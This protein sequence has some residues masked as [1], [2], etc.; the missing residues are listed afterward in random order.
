M[1]VT[2]LVVSEVTRQRLGDDGLAEL[3]ECLWPVDCQ[4]CGRFLGDD[5]PSVVADDLDAVALVSLHHQR[6]RFPVWNDSRIVVAGSGQY[7]TFVVRLMLLPV[8]VDGGKV[9]AC[10]LMLVN[11]G[12]ECVQLRRTEGGWQVGHDDWVA[13]A[14]RVRPG[15]DLVLGAPADGLVARTTD[16]SVA[17]V[18]QFPP[19]TVYEGPADDRLLG[20]ARALGGLLV[21]VTPTL[22]PGDL[23]FDDV[24]EA[25]GDPRTLAGWA[26]LHRIRRPPRR[27]FRLHRPVWVLCWSHDLLSVG[28]L[29]GQAPGKLTADRARAWAEHVL[30]A[31]QSEP[32]TWRSVREG[33]L[34]EGWQ[35]RGLFSTREHVLRRHPDGWKLVLI[36]AQA[37]GARAETDNEA[38]AWAANMLK[39]HAGISHVTWRPGPSVSGS[40]TLYG[41]A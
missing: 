17:V 2:T 29:L 30:S 39:L 6:C 35:A 14:G 12:L 36:C 23:V 20:R 9:A 18:L 24:V 10:P 27:R 31:G 28:R 11:P 5:P 22:N 26:G 33:R 7:T 25:L 41:A 19:F 40:V 34:D 3:A 32:L 4:S 8:I 38:K 13:R 21:A 15:R 16:S 1:A 37:N